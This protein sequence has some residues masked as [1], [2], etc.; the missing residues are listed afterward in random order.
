MAGVDLNNRAHPSDMR[1]CYSA[2]YSGAG[3]TVPDNSSARGTPTDFRR[4]GTLPPPAGMRTC[5]VQLGESILPLVSPID[6][7]R[8]L[9]DTNEAR[10][11]S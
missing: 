2:T 10:I 3:L 7:L 1:E 9:R 11:A 8:C 6:F 5:S 4:F